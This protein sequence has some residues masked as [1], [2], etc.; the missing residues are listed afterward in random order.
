MFLS[1]ERLF[2]FPLT[3]KIELMNVNILMQDQKIYYLFNCSTFYLTF[4]LI[5][6]ILYFF[7][8]S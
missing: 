3:K 7:N 2:V 5:L 6:I 4:Q 8:I 1:Y